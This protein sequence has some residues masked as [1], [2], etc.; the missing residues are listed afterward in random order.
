MD[1]PNIASV[2]YGPVL[3]AMEEPSRLSDWRRVSLNT[4]DL[5]QSIKGDP[6]TLRFQIGNLQLKP[7]FETY[8]RY[9]VYFDVAS[10]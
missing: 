5:S 4:D 9:S 6:G 8:G 1:Q 10:Q 3:L 2:F 7:F